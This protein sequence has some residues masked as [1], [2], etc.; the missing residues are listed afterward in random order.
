MKDS[1][2]STAGM[3]WKVQCWIRVMMLNEETVRKKR[4][5]KCRREQITPRS[6]EQKGP[7]LLLAETPHQNLERDT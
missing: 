6:D 5:G 2:N 7:S 1:P 4:H 3:E